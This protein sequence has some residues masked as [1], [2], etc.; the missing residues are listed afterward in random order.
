[1]TTEELIRRAQNGDKEAG[2]QLV[3]E[4]S[5]L[6]WSVARRFIGRGVEIDDL[7]QLGCLGFLKAVNGF[8]LN[9]VRSFLP[10]LSP[11][12][13]GRSGGFCGMTGL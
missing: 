4:N 6:V 5:G 3:T 7:Y 13:Q 9:T 12:L 2:E 8:D 11:K 1:M 10:M